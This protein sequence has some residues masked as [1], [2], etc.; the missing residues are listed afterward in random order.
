MYGFSEVL[1]RGF[2]NVFDEMVLAHAF[3][4]CSEETKY[5]KQR[6]LGSKWLHCGVSVTCCVLKTMTMQQV[7][8]S[9]WSCRKVR[10]VL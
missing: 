8:E 5:A 9:S 3:K 6:P 10:G 7:R 4:F 1:D 2:D